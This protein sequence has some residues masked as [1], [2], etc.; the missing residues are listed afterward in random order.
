MRSAGHRPAKASDR[1]VN[2]LAKNCQ[3][4]S[5]TASAAGPTI[6]STGPPLVVGVPSLV[7]R[8][9]PPL[10]IGGPPLVKSLCCRQHERTGDRGGPALQLL[11]LRPH[12]SDRLTRPGESLVMPPRPTCVCVS[13]ARSAPLARDT[14]TRGGNVSRRCDE[15]PRTQ[16]RRVHVGHVPTRLRR[17]PERRAEAHGQAVTNAFEISSDT[18]VTPAGCPQGMPAG[19]RAPR[20]GFEPAWDGLEVHCLSPLGHRGV[21]ALAS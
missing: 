1:N 21:Q 19:Q 16:L 7:I 14:T 18:S 11:P 15:A 20:A 17:R 10:V 13:Q 12:C 6:H 2:E 8:A 3:R 4:R 5:L 9:G